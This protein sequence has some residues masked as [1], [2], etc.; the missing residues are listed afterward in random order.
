LVRETPRDTPREEE[1]KKSEVEVIPMLPFNQEFKIEMV[2][3]QRPST[4]V[5]NT[6]SYK[7]YVKN[8]AKP[9]TPVHSDSV[10]RIQAPPNLIVASD[11]TKQSFDL[12]Q[13]DPQL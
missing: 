12:E 5:I 8:N 6:V 1:E 13:L 10:T 11:S 4:N 2:N 3:K 7:S 9:P